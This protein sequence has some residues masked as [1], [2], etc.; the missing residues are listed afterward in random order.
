MAYYVTRWNRGVLPV[1]AALAVLFMV[2]AIVA[3]PGWFE[4]DKA[5]FDDPALE[6]GI[7][8]LLTL[9]LIPVQLLLDRLRPPRL[10]PGVERRGRGRRRRE[11]GGAHRP[12][13]S[14]GARP[15]RT[16]A[17]RAD[18]DAVGAAAAAAAERE[19]QGDQ[20]P[21]RSAH[22]RSPSYAGYRPAAVLELAY[23]A[24]SKPAALRGL[25]V[26]IPPA[27]LTSADGRRPRSRRRPPAATNAAS[28]RDVSISRPGIST[29]I[30][31]GGSISRSDDHD[32]QPRAGEQH[33]RTLLDRQR[34]QRVARPRHRDRDRNSRRARRSRCRRRRRT[35]PSRWTWASATGRRRRGRSA[36]RR[37][38]AGTC[39]RA[40]PSRQPRR[41]SRRG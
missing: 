38:T 11:R 21:G 23:R 27:A 5:G 26:R 17:A 2:I 8:G 36:R 12:R 14:R 40:G 1:A 41:S 18:R 30:R 10:Q 39:R 33:E 4:R 31:S 35:T 13:G 16:R 25:W 20:R 32:E 37:T 28:L 29:L 19:Q 3:A 34:R 6:P 24:G 15:P 9:I 7:L 22:P